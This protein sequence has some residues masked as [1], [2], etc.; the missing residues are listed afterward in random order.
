ME[1]LRACTHEYQRIAGVGISRKHP[2]R[3]WHRNA[4]GRKSS[5]YILEPEILW[6]LV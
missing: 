4:L 3:R 2:S 1:N 5:Y 6:S